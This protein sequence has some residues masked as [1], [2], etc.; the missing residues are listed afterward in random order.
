M[1]Q[2]GSW[3]VTG[4]GMVLSHL[5]RWYA[6]WKEAYLLN[7]SHTAFWQSMQPTQQVLSSGTARYYLVGISEPAYAACV[8][9]EPCQGSCTALLAG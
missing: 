8:A 2:Q 4:L 9:S 3:C 7:N 5:T 1:L 6:T